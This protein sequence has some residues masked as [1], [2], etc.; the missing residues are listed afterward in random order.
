MCRIALFGLNAELRG[1]RV[2]ARR[3]GAGCGAGSGP[4]SVSR[5]MGFRGRGWR[6]SY[7]EAMRFSLSRW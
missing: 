4:M 6:R 5:W 2:S 7:R 1:R 3:Y